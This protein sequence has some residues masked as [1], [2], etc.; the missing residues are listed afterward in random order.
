MEKFDTKNC[1]ALA[2][3]YY[4]I[5]EAAIRVCDLMN[6]EEDIIYKVENLLHVTEPFSWWPR[7]EKMVECLNN[8]IAHGDLPY[9]EGSGLK[10]LQRFRRTVRHH[11]L[12][13]WFE[14]YY[15]D[16]RPAF[17]FDEVERNTHAVINKDTFQD[18]KEERDDLLGHRDKDQ[19]RITELEHALKEKTDA[20]DLLSTQTR[21]LAPH[22]KT[23]SNNIIG[24]LVNAMLA[25]SPLSGNKN[26]AFDSQG[27]IIEYLLANHP[28]KPGITERTLQDRFAAG[29]RSLASS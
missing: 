23:V 11:D 20:Y 8:A 12:K 19:M 24:A 14:K 22:S 15:P 9:R 3:P 6:L 16:Q 13:A 26:S 21:E 27:A 17:L 5:L 29:K 18:L 2:K 1:N 28:N 7:L 25:E 4:T 10:N